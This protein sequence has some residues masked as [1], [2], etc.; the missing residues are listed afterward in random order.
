MEKYSWWQKLRRS[1]LKRL[2]YWRRIHRALFKF[3]GELLPIIDGERIVVRSASSDEFDFSMRHVRIVSSWGLIQACDLHCKKPGDH[4]MYMEYLQGL[5][6]AMSSLEDNNRAVSIYVKV[7]PEFLSYFAFKV[8]PELKRPFILVT[9]DSDNPIDDTNKD[10]IDQI[11]RQSQ[12][13]AWYSQNLNF[14]HDRMFHLPIGLDYHTLWHNPAF[15]QGRHVFPM[16][17]EGEL[18]DVLLQS[19]AFKEREIKAYCNWHFHPGRGDRQ[20]CMQEVHPDACYF[21]ARPIPRYQ[22]WINQSL[23]AFVISPEGN[24]MDCHR[25]WEAIA[26]GSIPILK[27]NPITTMFEGLPVIIVDDWQAV[28]PAFLDQQ[29]V[30]FQNMKFDYSKIWLACWKDKLSELGEFTWPSMTLN[31]FRRFL[32]VGSL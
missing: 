21:E 12:F 3:L 5:P 14:N 19:R 1:V 20:R 17:Q 6:D 31:E 8:A 25:T 24:G 18:F 11:T 27:K 23:F 22:T 9:G 30:I 32:A 15:W 16:H 29:A 7:E 28:T 10:A 13:V 2:G 26:L 4:R